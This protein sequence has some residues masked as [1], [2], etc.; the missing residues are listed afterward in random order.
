MPPP[1]IGQLERQLKELQKRVTEL[2]ALIKG[3]KQEDQ[4]KS[5]S[6]MREKR[7]HA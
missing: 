6:E 4:Y 7:K 5:R 1:D 3:I 2:E